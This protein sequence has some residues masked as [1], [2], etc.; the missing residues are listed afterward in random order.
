[1][2]KIFLAFLNIAIAD[3][4]TLFATFLPEL[5]GPGEALSAV[6]TVDPTP[7]LLEELSLHL[8]P[9]FVVYFHELAQGLHDFVIRCYGA[10]GKKFVVD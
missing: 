4:L 3:V 9:L 10:R 1:M 2:K 6:T 5:A 8:N 7:H